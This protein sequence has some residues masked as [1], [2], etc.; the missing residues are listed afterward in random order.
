MYIIL[1]IQAISETLISFR[2]LTTWPIPIEMV[3]DFN[4]MSNN[5]LR[6]FVV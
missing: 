3:S 6:L 1:D 4:S 5:N 2:Y